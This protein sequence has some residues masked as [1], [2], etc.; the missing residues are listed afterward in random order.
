MILYKQ[1]ILLNLILHYVMITTTATTTSMIIHMGI[2]EF[3]V[4]EE[5]EEQLTEYEKIIDSFTELNI[6]EKIQMLLIQYRHDM[7]KEKH[8]NKKI[9]KIGLC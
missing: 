5:D 3:V 4:K 8:N 9:I 6:S 7:I 2:V 1:P